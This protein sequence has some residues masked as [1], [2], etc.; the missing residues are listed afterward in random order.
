MYYP[1]FQQTWPHTMGI[2]GSEKRINKEGLNSK[3]RTKRSNLGSVF[4]QK[5]LKY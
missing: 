5:S 3:L 1:I 4:G 2:S